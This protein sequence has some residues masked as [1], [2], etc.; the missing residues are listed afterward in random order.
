MTNE[1]QGKKL[2]QVIGKA[3]ADIEFKRKLIS[4]LG[5][6]LR[7]EGV[8]LHEGLEVRVV[9]NIGNLLFIGLPMTSGELSE[10]ELEMAAG[11]VSPEPA[12]YK[13]I[14]K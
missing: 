7:E 12:H 3:L 2:S 5:M 11:G 1:E 14:Q 9:Q 10:E 6:V 4:N 8:K 13:P